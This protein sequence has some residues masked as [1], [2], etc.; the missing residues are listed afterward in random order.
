MQLIFVL[1]YL[2]LGIVQLFAFMEGLDVWLGLGFW[3]SVVAFV[4]VFML[5]SFGGL[6]VAVVGFFGAMEGWGW[7]WWQAALLSFP[8]AILGFLAMGVSTVGALFQGHVASR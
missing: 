5:G 8:F 1:L 3:L 4:I 6:I 2:A 7:E